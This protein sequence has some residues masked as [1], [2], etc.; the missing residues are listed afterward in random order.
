MNLRSLVEKHRVSTKLDHEQMDKTNKIFKM[1]PVHLNLS[2]YSINVLTQLQV[3]LETVCVYL[4]VKN[5]PV[6]VVVGVHAR[7]TF[8]WPR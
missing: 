6:L 5:L 3:S 7:S 2:L 8:P 1:L 4:S